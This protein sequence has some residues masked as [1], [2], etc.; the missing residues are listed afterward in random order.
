MERGSDLQLREESTKG[1]LT[2]SLIP[3]SDLLQIPTRQ[4][5]LEARRQEDHFAMYLGLHVRV[6][7]GY[8]RVDGGGRDMKDFSPYLEWNF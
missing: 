7:A 4:N 5:Q 3:S 2:V 8:K 1:D 6:R